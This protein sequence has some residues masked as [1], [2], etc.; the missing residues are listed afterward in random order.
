MKD[1]AKV[2]YDWIVLPKSRL[3][4]L[5]SFQS[6]GG[7]A[8]V[9]HSHFFALEC[10]L[11]CGNVYHQGLGDKGVTLEVFQNAIVRRHSMESE[12]HAYVKS[13]HNVD[14]SK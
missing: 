8:Y 5:M 11:I 13:E 4:M 7:L 10:F 12:G 9:C 6:A 2:L 14:D 3:R 1:H